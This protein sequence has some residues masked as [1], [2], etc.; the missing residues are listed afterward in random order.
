MDEI[1][2]GIAI[3]IQLTALGGGTWTARCEVR[4]GTNTGAGVVYREKDYTETGT[5]YFDINSKVCQVRNGYS[6]TGTSTFTLLGEG[7]NLL[8]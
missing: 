2:D 6:A 3:G 4:I 7:K 5:D 1:V 8:K